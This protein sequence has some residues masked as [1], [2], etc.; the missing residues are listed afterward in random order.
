MP[1][2]GHEHVHDATCEHAGGDPAAV[3]RNAGLRVTDVRLA[4]LGLLASSRE[5]LDAQ[6]LIA[7]L[8]ASFDR[9]TVYRTLS[10]LV[11]AGIA[12]KVD[13]GDRRFRFS[14]TSHA[15]CTPEHHAHDHPHLLCDVCGRV[16]CMDDAEV[17]IRRVPGAGGV[18]SRGGSGRAARERGLGSATRGGR[19]RV[20]QQSVTVHG[21]CGTCDRRESPPSAM[22]SGRRRRAGR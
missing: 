17:V 11:D 14:L 15:R 9:V 10:S 22:R 3:L 21:T 16:E 8:R 5:A 13:P 4:V 18:G 12:H 2:G 19:W 20:K 1:A 7:R 6:D